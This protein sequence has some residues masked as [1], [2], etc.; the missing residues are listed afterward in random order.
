M[1]TVHAFCNYYSGFTDGLWDRPGP[2]VAFLESAGLLDQNRL[3]SNSITTI[4][5]NL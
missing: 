2:F 5:M 3:E 4:V 1:I